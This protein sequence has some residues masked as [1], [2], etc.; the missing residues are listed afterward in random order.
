MCAC[1]RAR[2]RACVRARVRACAR[3]HVLVAEIFMLSK[4]SDMSGNQLHEYR[5]SNT[6]LWTALMTDT[7]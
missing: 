2:V 4:C 3:A 5:N 1:A 7:N 6:L